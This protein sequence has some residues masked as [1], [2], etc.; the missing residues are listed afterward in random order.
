M[1]FIRKDANMKLKNALEK[2][3]GR[4]ERIMWGIG[5][6]MLVVIRTLTKGYAKKGTVEKF[7]TS[8]C[9]F[10]MQTKSKF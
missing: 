2:F 9:D 7:F 3:L 5:V 1:I 10:F 6:F 8:S 4:R